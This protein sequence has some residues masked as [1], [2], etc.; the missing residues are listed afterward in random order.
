MSPK[1]NDNHLNQRRKQVRAVLLDLDG[2]LVDS[3]PL[4]GLSWQRALTPLGGHVPGG[5]ENWIGVPDRDLARRIHEQ[6]NLGRTPEALLELK[7]RTYRRIAAEKLRPFTGVVEALGAMR[8]R[9]WPL[10]VVTSSTTPTALASLQAAG[11]D[12]LLPNRVTY[13]QT[14]AHKPDPEPYLLGARAAGIDPARCAAIED[15]TAGISAALAAGCLTL[16]VLHAATDPN[17][18][19]GAHATFTEPAQA[20]RWLLGED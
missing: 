12:K 13:E 9:D 2:V 5:W 19:A 18:S 4:H 14:D 3:E 15:S 17:H 11:L 1:P 6:Q 7:R 8:D 20:M 16:A 10:V